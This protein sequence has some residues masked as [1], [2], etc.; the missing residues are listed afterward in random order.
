[1]VG[2]A[3]VSAPQKGEPECWQTYF[4]LENKPLNQV[5]IHIYERQLMDREY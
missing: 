5:D 4:C 3:G 1:M 2:R